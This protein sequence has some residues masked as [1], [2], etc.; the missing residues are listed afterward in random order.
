MNQRISANSFTRLQER[1]VEAWHRNKNV[2][3]KTPFETA[4]LKQHRFNYD[5]WHEEDEARRKDV[6]DHIIAGVKRAID[7]LNQQRNDAIESLDLFLISER[8][9][10]KVLPKKNACLNSETPGSVID[11]LSILAL[12]L[13][14]M[15]AE[16]KRNNADNE[17]KNRC[18]KK[19]QVLIEQRKDLSGA[20]DR[21]IADVFAG[22]KILKVY[23][24]YKMYND[25]S[26][27]PS[28][29]KRTSR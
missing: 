2:L 25:P 11:R 14:H 18:Q 4:V 28:L 19:I 27:N 1:A 13:Y 16:V 15:R 7:K 8:D 9:E 3:P 12:R 17:H 22:K 21:L 5:L 20:F 29:Y 6:T 10:L 23:R 26:L 24:Q